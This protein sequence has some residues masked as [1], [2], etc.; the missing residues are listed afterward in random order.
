V[1][2][3]SRTGVTGAAHAAPPEV[4]DLVVRIKRLAENPVCVGFGISK[5]EHVRMVCEVADGAVVGS[6]LVE[7]L[8]RR[9]DGGRGSRDVVAAVRELK[10]ATGG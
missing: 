4:R 7:L 8:H 2:A 10:A 9:W 3:V 5:P 1:Y 6:W